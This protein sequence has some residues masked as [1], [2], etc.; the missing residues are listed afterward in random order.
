MLQ[1][2]ND[3]LG[4]TLQVQHETGFVIERFADA[5]D[6]VKFHASQSLAPVKLSV[7]VPAFNVEAFISQTLESIACNADL[8]LEVILVDDGSTDGTA[9]VAG[10]VLRRTHQRHVI[11]SQPNGGLSAA[12]NLGI[13]L[14][15]GEYVAFLDGDDLMAPGAYK[16]MADYADMFQCDQV[17][18]RGVCFANHHGS[19]HEFHD[20]KLYDQILEGQASKLV[21]P[22]QDARLFM[23]EPSVC[24]RIWRREFLIRHS[25][26]FP[27]GKLFED[28]GFHLISMALAQRVGIM[29]IQGLMYRWHR[30]GSITKDSSHRR[31]EVLDTIGE[32]LAHP[33]IKVLNRHAG[34]HLLASIIRISN[35]C[36][37]FICY[38]HRPEF[39]RKYRAMCEKIPYPWSKRLMRI[40]PE[41]GK[42]FMD[43]LIHDRPVWRH[44]KL[45]WRST[46][47]KRY[48]KQ[49]KGMQAQAPNPAGL[50]DQIAVRYRADGMR[51]YGVAVAASAHDALAV[52]VV[53]A[54]CFE[55]LRFAMWR[56]KSTVLVFCADHALAEW[57]QGLALQLGLGNLKAHAGWKDAAPRIR[58]SGRRVDLLCIQQL[59]LAA[60]LDEFKDVEVSH[61]CA[62]VAD[63]PD[64]QAIA[65]AARR[66]ARAGYCLTL[67]DNQQVSSFYSERFP[68]DVSV[69]VPV[70]N[71]RDWLAASLNSLVAQT[72]TSME[73]ILVDDGSTDGSGE[74]CDAWAARHDFIRVIHKPNGGCA[75]ARMAGLE[76]ARGEY[77]AFLDADDWL[78]PNALKG[79]LGL[80]MLSRR[81]VVEGGWSLAFPSGKTVDK[82][83][84]ELGKC[85]FS[86]KGGYWYRSATEAMLGSPAIWRRLY[87]RAYLVENHIGFDTTLRRYDDAPFNFEVLSGLPE[88]PY[89]PETVIYYRQEREGQDVGITDDRLFIHFPISRLMRNHAFRF[90]G[91]NLLPRYRTIK[92]SMH[93]WAL[94]KIDSALHREYSLYM[95]LDLFGPHDVTSSL[96]RLREFIRARPKERFFL[97]K[98]YVL[99]WT[100]ARFMTL[101]TQVR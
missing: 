31:L 40:S 45:R 33:A 87:R 92:A 49:F 84:G 42:L 83:P 72:L 41:H 65:Q 81:D 62:G 15:R 57:Y 63:A 32:T 51:Q 43:A 4:I 21:V 2:V 88:V 76:A 61:L 82:M 66:F 64:W 24:P 1:F 17:L 74:I 98:L 34:A 39:Q 5:A 9:E 90:P 70:Y 99:Y 54:R 73:V 48:A 52:H 50:K 12:R 55:A 79:L 23:M 77:V 6:A 46:Y 60:Q 93:M 94:S 8:A 101:P 25:L 58:E 86:K 3:K 71:V 28:I 47:L 85:K 19:V 20:W 95:A 27:V 18:S 80:A 22:S 38:E 100:R 36:K 67:A 69:V 10:E 35:W 13:Q 96:D 29:D 68:V 37:D 78:A 11:V 97:I 44:L 30:P 14:A 16:A 91:R 26:L 7:I 53:E 59:R 89:L 56:P 75:S